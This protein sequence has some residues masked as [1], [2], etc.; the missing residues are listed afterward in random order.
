MYF[1]V[2]KKN[3]KKKNNN[4]FLTGKDHVLFNS[5]QE[6]IEIETW[7]HLTFFRCLHNQ[8]S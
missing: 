1:V 3:Y 8:L 2:I 7:L 5:V 6:F 4:N